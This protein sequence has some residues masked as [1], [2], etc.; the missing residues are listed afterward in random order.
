LDW[1]VTVVDHRPSHIGDGR[2]AGAQLLLGACSDLLTVVDVA[3]CHATVV[4][5][6]HLAS[7]AAYLRELAAAGVPAYV[8]LFG[9]EGRCARLMQDLGAAAGV[10]QSR[11]HGPVGL[12]H[13]AI[14]PEAIA[15]AIVS[16]IHAWLA[17]RRGC[18]QGRHHN[19]KRR[20][21]HACH[22]HQ[23]G[24]AFRAMLLVSHS[25]KTCNA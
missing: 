7:D 13:G 2:F 20:S 9:P 19:F 18:D 14:T 1:R 6:D 8:G 11:L 10:L 24:G 22:R 17:G 4:M 21:A 15:L 5:S 16:E 23:C 25:R 3:R 12:N